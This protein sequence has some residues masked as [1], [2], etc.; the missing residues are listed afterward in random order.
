MNSKDLNSI[1][2]AFVHATT[3]VVAEDTELTTETKAHPRHT[4]KGTPGDEGGAR[5][6]QNPKEPGES[7]AS[8][9]KWKKGQR[10]TNP[11]FRPD[12]KD[13]DE[14]VDERD[15][16][17]WSDE[18]VDADWVP[19]KGESVEVNHPG[20]ES[21]IGTIIGVIDPDDEDP[22]VPLNYK[23]EFEDG[24]TEV[25]PR[26]HLVQ[27][28]LGDDE[29][30][31]D[32]PGSDEVGSDE[33]PWDMNINDSVNNI[34]DE[35]ESRLSS[36]RYKIKKNDK[37]NEE[38]GTSYKQP[39]EKISEVDSK[40]QRP[41]GE[42]KADETSKDVGDVKKDLQEPVEADEKD[43][44]E[45]KKVVKESINNC[46][47][48]NIMSEDKSIFDKLYEQVM[49]EDDDFELGIPGDGGPDLGD[50]FGD[51]GGEDV[52]V[53]LTPDQ[54]DALKAIVDQL[55]PAD[56]ENGDDLGDELGLGDEEPEENFRRESTDT[57]EEDH[58]PSTGVPTQDGAKPG[59]DPS[60]GGGKTTEVDGLGGKVSGTGDA[61]VTDDAPSTGKETG[62]G[63]KPGVHKA[64]GKPKPLKAKS[65]T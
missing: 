31:P 10:I 39:D 37:L 20:A 25:H 51:E 62:E 26:P 3:K 58:T 16:S 60:D 5:V 65:K 44:K 17:S 54:A 59:V 47:K 12:T 11:R 22:D 4:P 45:Q 38:G 53:T 19:E 29:P 50:E 56:D 41:K 55:A 57:V 28:E 61:K 35:Y 42:V 52:T 8:R 14:G 30:G 27:N 7:G 13:P 63:K 49:G 9:H 34:M 43:A 18:P 36:S 15:M 32:D 64:G 1:N 24:A 21:K 33:D 2:E 46:N 48:G 23:I 40:T 6:F